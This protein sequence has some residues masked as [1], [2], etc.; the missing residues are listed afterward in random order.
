MEKVFNR[1]SVSLNGDVIGKDKDL[2]KPLK[3]KKNRETAYQTKEHLEKM[4]KN[5]D[6]TGGAA[7][8]V[9][10]DVVEEQIKFVSRP[11]RALCEFV[12]DDDNFKI[13]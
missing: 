1:S 4:V 12:E 11:S 13:G 8:E 6:G 2:Q 7:S 9:N 5:R 3:T 10:C